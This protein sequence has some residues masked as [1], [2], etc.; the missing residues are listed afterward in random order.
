MEYA[1]DVVM[2]ADVLL[3]VLIDPHDLCARRTE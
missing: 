2:T 3:H 1:L